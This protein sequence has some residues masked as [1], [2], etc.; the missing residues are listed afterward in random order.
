[1]NTRTAK[2]AS[3]SVPEPRRIGAKFIVV[4]GGEEIPFPTTIGGYMISGDNK[5]APGITLHMPDIANAITLAEPQ[6]R[7]PRL[8][9]RGLG[10]V[11]IGRAPASACP[12][13]NVGASGLLGGA[14][15]NEDY[16]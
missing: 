1:M 2:A 16:Q 10:P 14:T 12:G 11:P 15:G 7:R 9:V 8:R 6:I 4:K 13:Q 3:A 5:L